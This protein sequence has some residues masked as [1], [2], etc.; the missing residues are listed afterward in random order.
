MKS[1]IIFRSAPIKSLILLAFIAIFSFG[2]IALAEGR[3]PREGLVAG[4]Y[5]V[6]LKDDV[7]N[8]DQ[9]EA[10]IVG[11]ARG[12]SIASYRTALLGFAVRMSESE[13]AVV[14]SDP[15]VAFVS[16]DRIVSAVR[17]ER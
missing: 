16:E 2:T 10:E 15:R 9:A 5:I 1:L 3:E 7:E 14:T 6:V 13:L 12:E 8:V 17:D 4:Q 11:R